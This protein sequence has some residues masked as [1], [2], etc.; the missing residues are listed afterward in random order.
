MENVEIRYKDITLIVY[1]VYE[2]GEDAVMRYDDGTGYDG[3]P[4]SF[5]AR[6]IKVEDSD[7]DIISLLED[8]LEEIEEVCLNLIES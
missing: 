7:I 8:D 5:E 1:G 6:K 2:K 3:S 4:S